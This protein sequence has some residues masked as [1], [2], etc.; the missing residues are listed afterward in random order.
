MVAMGTGLALVA[1]VVIAV[2]LLPKP[3]A[4]SSEPAG[5]AGALRVHR[6]VAP[7]PGRLAASATLPCYVNGAS[8]GSLTV[9]ACG[10][11][12]GVAS[13]RLDVGL[14]PAQPTVAA[15]P[16]APAPDQTQYASRE[17][18]PSDSYERA[19]PP[20][21][22]A[23]RAFA[24]PRAEPPARAEPSARAP[25][26]AARMFAM[27]RPAPATPLPRGALMAPPVSRPAAAPL[28]RAAPGR[29]AYALAPTRAYASN[30]AP[31]ASVERPDPEDSVRAAQTFYEGLANADGAQ[32]ASV[33]VPEKRH[34]GP[35]SAGAIDRFYS[36][37]QEPLRLTRLYP[38]DDHTV[39]ARYAFVNRDGE[40]CH[41]TARVTT[42]QRDGDVYVQGVRA[43]NGC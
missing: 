34:Q 17:P 33:V 43:L 30:D 21:A 9:A 42:T 40:V 4:V 28:S 27:V 37:L 15:A 20:P 11:R 23:P 7:Q 26:F 38:V 41:G 1:G 3:G 2:T 22:P 19:A 39:V 6:Y 31:S 12:N 24:P 36:Q 29:D 10:E 8:V 18:A 5:P 14:T 16:P 35:L 13:G 25:S 32:A